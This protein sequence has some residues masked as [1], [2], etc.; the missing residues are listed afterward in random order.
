VLVT[1]DDGTTAMTGMPERPAFGRSITSQTGKII[2]EDLAGTL[3]AKE[4]TSL[5]EE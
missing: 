2:R 4:C 1:V 5:M 3:G